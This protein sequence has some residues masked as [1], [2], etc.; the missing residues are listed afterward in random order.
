MKMIGCVALT[1]LIFDQDLWLQDSV[2]LHRKIKVPD[3][4]RGKQVVPLLNISLHQLKTDFSNSR[5]GHWA[6]RPRARPTAYTEPDRSPAT[7]QAL[8]GPGLCEQ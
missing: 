4:I 3:S 5:L 6:K 8:L 1:T 7:S 2:F